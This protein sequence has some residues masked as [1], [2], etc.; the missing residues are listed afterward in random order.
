MSF[1]RALRRDGLKISRIRVLTNLSIIL[2][3]ALFSGLFGPIPQ[4]HAQAIVTTV[5][6][7]PITDV[8]VAQ[9]MKLLH[10]LRKPASREA[11]LQS[12]ID[13]QLMRGEATKYQINVGDPQ[14]G[15]EIVRTANEMKISPETL[16]SEM[17]R[18]GV[19][20]THYKDHFSAVSAFFY[21]VEA[22]HKG[23]QPSETEIRAA[24]AKEGGKSG[25]NT[26][27]RVHQVIFIIPSGTNL[28]QIKGRMEA[29]QQLRTRFTNCASGLSLARAMDNVAVKEE[30][31]RNSTELAAPLKTLLDK[32][33][34]GHLTPPQRTTSGIEM[35]AVCSKSASTDESALRAAISAKL[36]TAIIEKAAAKR[37]KELRAHA[38]IA[39]K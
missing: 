39:K 4:A 25:G 26:E 9:R 34:T 20:Q 8:D 13:D 35:I 18:V 12:L 2:A 32:T 16:V 23:V 10:V 17:Q 6:G 3:A 38:I 21:L 33:P 24:L 11:A 27:Y 29:A 37:L 5:N 7:A 36:L 30:I 22:F 19:S 1:F 15:Q 14:I 31:V 28:N